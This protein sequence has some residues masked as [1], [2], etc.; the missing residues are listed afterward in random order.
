[1]TVGFSRILVP[2]DGS[3]GALRA[4]RF[5]AALARATGAELTLLHVHPTISA[6]VIGM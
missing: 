5:A 2:V 3:D 4:V 1:M 6:E